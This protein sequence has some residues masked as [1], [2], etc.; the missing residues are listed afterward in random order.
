MFLIPQDFNFLPSGLESE[1]AQDFIVS[2]A[3]MD[4]SKIIDGLRNTNDCTFDL[5]FVSGQ[6]YHDLEVG[7][8]NIRP[9]LWATDGPA[10]V[11]VTAY[12]FPVDLV[13]PWL[14]PKQPFRVCQFWGLL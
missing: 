5:L 12:S 10:G 1:A 6:L 4:L 8:I 13:G 11:P 14:R 9:L 7:N 3:T 2:M